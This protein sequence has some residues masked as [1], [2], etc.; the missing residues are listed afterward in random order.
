[1]GIKFVISD[2]STKKSHQLDVEKDKVVTIFN[3]KIGE[4][5]SGDHLG[6][7]GYT[8][9]IT[10]GSDKDGFPMRPDVEGIG[11]KRI[12]IGESIGFHPTI[13]GE[14]KRRTVRGNTISE[15]T[16]QVNLKVMKA[17]AKSLEE[18]HP[19]KKKEEKPAEAPKQ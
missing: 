11:R 1:M 13:K 17:G 2:P 8:L 15:D 18:L 6:L 7:H 4:D 10:G 12:L 14:R 16:H 19:S 9:K 5:I 3:K